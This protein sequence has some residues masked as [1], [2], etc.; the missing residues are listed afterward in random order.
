MYDKINQW[1]N[2][3]IHYS[4]FRF[5]YINITK[6]AIQIHF[7]A[8]NTINE[9]SSFWQIANS[10]QIV[11]TIWIIEMVMTIIFTS[12]TNWPTNTVT[13]N[14]NSR[15]TKKL[16]ITKMLQHDDISSSS[17]RTFTTTL[18]TVW[19]FLDK[20]KILYTFFQCSPSTT[21]MNY[22]MHDILQNQTASFVSDKTRLNELRSLTNRN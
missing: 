22:A 18:I 6:A 7:K 17:D 9:M 15:L 11:S 8:D 14:T 2:F 12:V 5:T 16:A 10:S 3:V 21:F 20:S 4:V 13:K 19:L 1:S